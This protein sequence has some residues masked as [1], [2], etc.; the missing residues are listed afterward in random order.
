MW[1]GRSQRFPQRE[2]PDLSRRK[3]L[4]SLLSR[5][6]EGILSQR[7]APFSSQSEEPF[8]LPYKE[9]YGEGAFS[10]RREEG[11]LTQ[12]QARREEAVDRP[13]RYCPNLSL[14]VARK[15]PALPSK[16]KDPFS[17]KKEWAFSSLSRGKGL[18][19]P[20]QASPPL[21]QKDSLGTTLVHFWAGPPPSPKSLSG[22]HLGTFSG[23]GHPRA[24]K[25]RS[26]TH[27]GG[28]FW[29]TGKA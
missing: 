11:I 3:G 20:G 10:L 8:S 25:C 17:C 5:R 13:L 27:S 14:C 1:Q 6:A 7:E 23:L 2:G 19:F 21:A 28:H 12:R 15:K 9:V 4:L 16:G 29:A 24:H 18:Y 26:G 22:D